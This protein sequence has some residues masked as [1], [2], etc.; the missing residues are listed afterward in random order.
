FEKNAEKGTV[1]LSLTDREGHT[2]IDSGE[3]ETY[4]LSP[5]PGKR[6]TLCVRMEK[7]SGSYKIE[8]V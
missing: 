5:V 4:T 7:A 2:L 8:I 6:Y 3:E 1:L